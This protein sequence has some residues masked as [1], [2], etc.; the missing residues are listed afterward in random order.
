M[1][2]LMLNYQKFMDTTNEMIVHDVC[3]CLVSGLSEYTKDFFER[4]QDY[5]VS[6]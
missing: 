3:H 1:S 6:P 4:I 5:Q 2:W